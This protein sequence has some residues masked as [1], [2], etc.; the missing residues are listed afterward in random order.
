MPAFLSARSNGAV[1]SSTWPKN[2]QF[3][4]ASQK[5]ET[6]TPPE[7]DGVGRLPTTKQNRGRRSAR[8]TAPA[9]SMFQLP[10]P[11]PQLSL[12]TVVFRM[13]PM[14]MVRRSPGPQNARRPRL[15]SFRRPSMPS[16]DPTAEVALFPASS[17]VSAVGVWS[18][19]RT[20]PRILSP[21]SPRLRTDIV[22][23]KGPCRWDVWKL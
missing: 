23:W 9:P 11:V 21:P 2:P 15:H 22:L 19:D 12:N 4:H 3:Y 6:D 18:R 7:P 17:R 8:P 14:Y 16:L 20:R 5:P 10:Q 1:G 13:T